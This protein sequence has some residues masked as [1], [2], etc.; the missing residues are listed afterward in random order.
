MSGRP[1][2]VPLMKVAFLLALSATFALPAFGGATSFTSDNFNSKNLLRPLWT[3]TDPL[4]DGHVKMKGYNSDSARVEITVPAGSVHDTWT[5]GYQSP[6]IMQACTNTDFTVEV[7]FFSGMRGTMNVNY[8]SQGVI[9]EQDSANLMRFDF[10]TGHFSDSTAAFGVYFQNGLTSPQTKIDRKYFAAYDVSP[11]W[12]RVSRKGDMWKMYYS[13]NG[14]SYT[15]V[16][17]FAHAINVSKIGLEAG[18]AGDNPK[19]FTSSVDYFFNADSVIS[20]EDSNPKADNLGPLI[21]DVQYNTWPNVL[22]VTYKT[23]EPGTGVM[24]YGTSTSYGSEQAYSDLSYDHRFIVPGLE[25]NTGYHFQVKSVDGGSNSTS[26]SDYS[27]T[28]TTYVDD[29]QLVSDDFYGSSI[30][31]G[32]WTSTNPLSD[33][34]FGVSGSKLSIAV[35]GGT[36]HDLWSDVY[37]VPRLM[38]A[39]SGDPNIFTFTVK[40]SGPMTGSASSSSMQGIIA[41]QDT[42]N[43]LRVNYA[44][45]GSSLT[46]FTAGFLKGRENYSIIDTRTLT[47]TTGPLW[48]RVVQGGG[49]FYVEYS[50]DGVTYTHINFFA[51]PLNVKKVGIFAG[52]VGTSPAA[53]TCYA[54]YIATTLPAKPNLELPLLNATDVPTPPTLTWDTTASATTYRVQVATDAAFSSP[55]YNDS[56]VTLT[57]KSVTGLAN[58]Q[59]YYWRVRGKNTSGVGAYSDIFNFTTAIAAPTVPTLVTPADNAVDVDPGLTLKWNK[60]ATAATYRLQVSADSAFGSFVV[61]DSTLTDTTKAMTGLSN[62]V[63]YY[64]R[65]NAKNAGGTSAYSTRRAFTTISAIPATPVMI[66]PPNGA[67]NQ[68]TSLTLRWYKVN[69]ATSY[70]VQVSTDPNFSSTFFLN[71]ST[72][73]DTVKSI[74]GLANST[75]YYWRVNAKN[76]AGTGTFATPWSFTTIVANPN[77]PSL[78]SPTDA[79]TNQDLNV[80]FT[81]TKPVGATSFRLQVG[82]DSTFATGLVVNDSTITDSTKTA[83]TFVYNQKYFWRVNAKNIG[84]TGPY[85]TVWSFRT[86]DADPSIPRLLS[87]AANAL[88]T[89][90]TVT[91]VW[92]RP[93]GTTSFHLQVATD[94]GFASGFVVNDPAASDTLRVLHGL[95]FLTKYFWRV[96]ADA[97]GGTSPY[98]PTRAFTTGI[99]MAAA[100]VA[101]SPLVAYPTAADS[102][103]LVWRRSAPLVDKYRAELAIDAAFMFLVADSTADTTIVFRSLTHNQNYFWRVRAHNAGGWGPFCAAVQINLLGV[104]EKDQMPTEYTLSQNYPNPFNPSTQIEFALPKES[105]VTLEIYNLLGQRVS[106]LVDQVLTAGYHSVR[107]DAANMPSGLYLYRMKAGESS[108]VRKMMLMK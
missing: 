7:K 108:F 66:T 49:R 32:L 92:S 99:A 93:A 97:V 2:F 81:W 29:T 70:R 69:Y 84:G 101:V 10:V 15:L 45:N 61:N 5:Q 18:N 74:S 90:T 59:K 83:G 106:T 1:R 42:N 51:W 53:F 86:Y 38:Q 27:A 39:V 23:D 55:I 80:K 31:T 41:E 9:V 4:G 75:Q 82:T 96:N 104:A 77:T 40:F 58:T 50:S 91:L 98:S 67:A 56:T 73:T 20:P 71:D 95:S 105:R 37:T 13:L 76:V 85:S 19:E 107:F 89:D 3:F 52:N 8:Q 94:S 14:S 63:K 103:R 68:Q 48:L 26:S 88:G 33:A 62:L 43:L 60:S 54:D 79:S 17:S 46:L 72:I 64:W 44:Y 36:N 6:R 87:P 35:P 24:D 12:M 28:T 30:N 102:V 11:L 78:V 65:V 22:L 57:N 25:V 47:T 34:T 100:P 16:D 21:Y